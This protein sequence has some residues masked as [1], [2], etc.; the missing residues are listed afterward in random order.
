[1]SDLERVKATLVKTGERLNHGGRAVQHTM[2]AIDHWA[3]A[4]VEDTPLLERLRHGTGF[5]S[6]AIEVLSSVASLVDTFRRTKP[7]QVES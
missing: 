6:S 1:M 7:P 4:T 3:A 2:D 5:A